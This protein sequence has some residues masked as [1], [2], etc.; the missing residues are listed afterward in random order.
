MGFDSPAHVQV[1]PD[2]T[3]KNIDA[4]QLTS[5]ETGNPTV[6]RQTITIGDPLSY[7][8]VAAVEQ[9]A[10][11]NRLI[12]FDREQ[13]SQLINIL[14]EQVRELRAIRIGIGKLIGEALFPVDEEDIGN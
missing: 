5:S 9:D 6:Y 8:A 14:T 3:G 13:T 2:S 11:Q 1:S 4:Q 12:V 10:S 7:D